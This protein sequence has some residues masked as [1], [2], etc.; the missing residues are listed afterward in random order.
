MR[1]LLL[2]ATALLG[3]TLAKDFYGRIA[4][5]GTVGLGLEMYAPVTC[6]YACRATMGSWMLDC[7]SSSSSSTDSM[8]HSGM[9][10]PME[11]TKRDMMDME[12]PTPLCYANNE[13]FLTSLAWCIY[14]YCPAD[15][16]IA[17]LE[18]Y[19]EDNV[20]GRMEGQPKPKVSYQHALGMVGGE[21]T[22][23][24]NSSEML[25]GTELVSGHMWHMN[26]GALE[27]IEVNIGLDNQYA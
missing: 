18:R 1:K 4:S 12:P 23:V 27:G 7:T 2:T 17:E 11:K 10:M 25:K 15:T 21:P 8:D 14:S 24:H 19:W 26:M 20:P 9:D 5:H 6:A 22:T 16:S 3:Q 13:P